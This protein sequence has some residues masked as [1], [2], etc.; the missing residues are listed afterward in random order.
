MQLTGYSITVTDYGVSTNDT[1]SC[2]S[3]ELRDCCLLTDALCINWEWWCSKHCPPTSSWSLATQ[4]IKSKT[5]KG[6]ELY[7]KLKHQAEGKNRFLIFWNFF[8]FSS[9][10]FAMNNASKE[11]FS[12]KFWITNKF[13]K[14]DTPPT[15]AVHLWQLF[16]YIHNT[17][18]ARFLIK[19]W[20]GCSQGLRHL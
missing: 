12:S 1:E 7:M 2:D 11:F 17:C 5:L 13:T 19:L 20:F 15:S 3:D 9:V 16:A 8:P 14:W 6:T 4:D 18:L 10:K